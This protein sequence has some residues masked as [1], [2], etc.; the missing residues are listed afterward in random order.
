[1]N[2]PPNQNIL[3]LTDELF[4][5]PTCQPELGSVTVIWQGWWGGDAVKLYKVCQ[6]DTARRSQK[7]PGAACI[8][9]NLN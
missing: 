2:F 1:M 7:A 8:K 6:R 5:S 3:Y 4:S 9:V